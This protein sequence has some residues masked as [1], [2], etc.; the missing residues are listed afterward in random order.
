[1]KGFGQV[2]MSILKL[3]LFL[4]FGSIFQQCEGTIGSSC[5]SHS[6]C[7]SSN[8]EYCYNGYWSDTCT[9]CFDLD[10]PAK[11]DNCKG[12]S[13]PSQCDCIDDGVT[14][15][16]NSPSSTYGS[17]SWQAKDGTK[18][19]CCTALGKFCKIGASQCTNA[20]QSPTPTPAPT[21]T[22][23]PTPTPDANPD[24]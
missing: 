6:S 2:T 7:S 3:F 19:P 5:S 21:P 20:V 16:S 12:N 4:S 14:C 9:S 24:A 11:S 23:T 8:Q 22:P 1:M 17:N 15:T 10:Y 13:C 18:W